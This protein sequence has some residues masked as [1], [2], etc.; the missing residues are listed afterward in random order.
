MH[1]RDKEDTPNVKHN[2]SKGP[3]TRFGNEPCAYDAV[4]QKLDLV[5]TLF[6]PAIRSHPKSD[7]KE[8]E[9]EMCEHTGVATPAEPAI[10]GLIA[11]VSTSTAVEQ[12]FI[13]ITAI[14]YSV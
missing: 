11:K 8:V 3:G 14:I 9:G 5:A 4:V 1:Y 12:S 7:G 2:S 13:N 10:I 6:Q